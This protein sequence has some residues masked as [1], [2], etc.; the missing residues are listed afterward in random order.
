MTLQE[1]EDRASS[2]ARY[3]GRGSL[4]G[5]VYVSLKLSGEAGEF[6]NK[7]GKIYG[8]MKGKITSEEREA[9]LLELGDIQWYISQACVELQSSLE[10]VAEGNLQKLHNRI[11]R[12]TIVGNGDHR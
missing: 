12:G 7:V 8:H 4:Q 5:L 11:K 2:T 1:Y 6:S 9:L 10:I 3:N